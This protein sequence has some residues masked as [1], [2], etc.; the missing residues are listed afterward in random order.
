[1]L[2]LQIHVQPVLSDGEPLTPN[3]SA[4]AR[5]E[6]FDRVVNIRQG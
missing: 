1:M 4:C 3:Q 2:L 5:F 6:L